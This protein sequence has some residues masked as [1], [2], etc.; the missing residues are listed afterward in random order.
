MYYL[1]VFEGVFLEFVQFINIYMLFM[2]VFYCKNAW[3]VLKTQKSVKSK[4]YF[5]NVF[6]IH[7]KSCSR[8]ARRRQV[9]QQ[10]TLCQTAACV[11]WTRLRSRESIVFVLSQWMWMPH[12]RHVTGCCCCCYG[13]HVRQSSAGEAG[14]THDVRGGQL[15]ADDAMLWML[16]QL[17]RFSFHSWVQLF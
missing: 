11:V 8:E 10:Q 3:K 17:T 15:Q 2:Q 5:K 14:V 9:R 1:L 16:P 13:N 6:Y 4:N 12:R 7:G